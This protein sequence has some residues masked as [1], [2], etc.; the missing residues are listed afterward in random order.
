MDLKRLAQHS[1]KKKSTT[2]ISNDGEITITNVIGG[3]S[4]YTYTIR[5]CYTIKS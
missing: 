2:D 3:V 4:P 1:F 5:L